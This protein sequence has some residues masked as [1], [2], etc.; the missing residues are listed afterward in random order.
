MTRMDRVDV[1]EAQSGTTLCR[2]SVVARRPLAVAVETAC[3]VLYFDR[4]T[5]R[6]LGAAQG[7]RVREALS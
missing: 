6:G 5:G 7:L 1:V 4:E 3:G 2:A